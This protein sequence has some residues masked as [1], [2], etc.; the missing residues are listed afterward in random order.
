LATPGSN[1][2]DASRS[3]GGLEWAALERG[4]ILRTA[5]DLT[6]YDWIEVS[7]SAGKDSL[8]MLWLIAMLARTAGVLHR[9]VAVHADLGRAEWPGT[10]EIARKQ[11]EHLG[12]RFELVRRPQ[13]D[14]LDLVRHYKHWPKPDSRYC[15]A[16]LKRGQILRVLTALAAETRRSRPKGDKRPV[17]ILNCIGLRAEESPG[18]AKQPSLKRDPRASGKGGRK[19]VDIWLPIQDMPEAEVWG[20]CRA[21]GAPMHPAYAAGLPRASCILCIYAPRDALLIAGRANPDLL[22]EYVALEKEI[23]HDFKHRLPIAQ[24]AADIAA[25]V[26]PKG[27]VKSWCM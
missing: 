9:V 11:A 10:A 20:S 19:L 3:L 23:G 21:S 26:M 7:T 8:A 6:A 2:D 22:A 17:K 4:T 5:P 15:T 13:G 27:P 18:R 12:V 1:A 24:V 16:M 25:G 14:L